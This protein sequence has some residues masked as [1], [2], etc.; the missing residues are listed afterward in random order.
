MPPRSPVLRC[1]DPVKDYGEGLQT[2]PAGLINGPKMISCWRC[3]SSFQDA[4]MR[5][6][7][8]VPHFGVSQRPGER[9]VHGCR[10]LWF[11][12]ERLA[13]QHCSDACCGFP[14]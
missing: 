6:G 9:I 12:A 5:N 4:V 8:T 7:A 1:P 11:Q 13:V 3:R 14:Q 2:R 10:L